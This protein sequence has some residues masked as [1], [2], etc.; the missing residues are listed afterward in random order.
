MPAGCVR[1]DEVCHKTVRQPVGEIAERTSG[2]ERIRDTLDRAL[3]PKDK[4]GQDDDRCYRQ[5]DEADPRHDPIARQKAEAHAT[6]EAET[7][8]EDGQ[9]FQPFGR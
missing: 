7:Q 5:G 1:L 3:G 4:R 6:I 8:I 9:Q 2:H